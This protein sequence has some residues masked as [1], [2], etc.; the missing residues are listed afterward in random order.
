MGIQI[1][2]GRRVQILKPVWSKTYHLGESRHRKGSKRQR[3]Y[4]H[5][6]VE[7]IPDGQVIKSL[8]TLMMN[9]KTW[10]KLQNAKAQ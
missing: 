4:R 7:L 3:F 10:Q 8:G 9:E 6:L 5:N 1:F 2:N